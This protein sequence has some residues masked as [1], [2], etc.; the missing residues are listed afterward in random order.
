MPSVKLFMSQSMER[1]QAILGHDHAI[2]TVEAGVT[3]PWAGVVGSDAL[4]IGIDSFGV[5]APLSALAE[6]YGFTQNQVTER[7]LEYLASR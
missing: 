5:S 7:V 4:H 6:R 3:L 2:V 1:R